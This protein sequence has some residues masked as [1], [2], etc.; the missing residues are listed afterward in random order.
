MKTSLHPKM[1][2]QIQLKV[3]HGEAAWGILMANEYLA[4]D[5]SLRIVLVKQAIKNGLNVTKYKKIIAGQRLSE[6]GVS[7]ETLECNQFLI[8][9]RRQKFIQLASTT[10]KMRLNGSLR[11]PEL[12]RRHT[13]ITRSSVSTNP[14]QHYKL[15]AV[16]TN[17]H[18]F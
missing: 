2:A 16:L 9:S 18:I 7:K 13:R 14:D 3:R 12:L 15:H 1:L 4:A 6:C 17:A 11:R 10:N 5:D 8:K